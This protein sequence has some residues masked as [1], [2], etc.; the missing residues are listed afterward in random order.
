M[1]TIFVLNNNYGSLQSEIIEYASIT[2]PEYSTEEIC[3]TITSFLQSGVL[4]T[5]QP[6]CRD[7]C[8]GG[9]ARVGIT[10]NETMDQTTA[11]QNL[12][13]FLIQLAGGTRGTGSNTTPATY[14]ATFN[15]LFK[16]Y[17]NPTIWDITPPSISSW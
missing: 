3:S 5:L 7:W 16:L 6:I 1:Y 2:F 17:V 12:V 4:R 14:S 9:T 10:F 13:L 11:N 15:A 8:S